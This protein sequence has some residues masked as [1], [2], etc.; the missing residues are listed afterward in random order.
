MELSYHKF[1]TSAT[2]PKFKLALNSDV[3]RIVQSRISM[4]IINCLRRNG[5]GNHHV[6]PF[7]K[8]VKLRCGPSGGQTESR[9]VSVLRLFYSR[10]MYLLG[11]CLCNQ[12]EV[13]WSESNRVVT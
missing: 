10:T 13:I 11:P 2:N 5:G 9:C 12:V 1:L 6:I 8:V 7:F 3:I 4:S